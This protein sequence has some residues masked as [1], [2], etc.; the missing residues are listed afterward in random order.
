M[1]SLRNVYLITEKCSEESM[2]IW[3]SKT[4]ILTSLFL[5]ISILLGQII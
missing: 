1:G 3:N 5:T 4:W 2:G